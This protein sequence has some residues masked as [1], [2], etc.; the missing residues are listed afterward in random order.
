MR[1]RDGARMEKRVVS[2]HKEKYRND[3]VWVRLMG[4]LLK[5]MQSTDVI[6][7]KPA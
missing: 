7:N 6:M 4:D 3:A 2:V 5:V 1:K